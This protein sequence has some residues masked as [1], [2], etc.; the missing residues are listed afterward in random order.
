M[1]ISG[2]FLN[3]RFLN[4]SDLPFYNMAISAL[5]LNWRFLNLSDLPFYN[6]AIS[7]LFWNWRYLKWFAILQYG[8]YC[9]I[10]KLTLS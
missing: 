10:F 1:A 5:F 7:A 6:M 2:L 4:L 9:A 8:D 3:W